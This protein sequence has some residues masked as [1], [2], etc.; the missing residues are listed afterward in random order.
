MPSKQK[1]A[2]IA[3]VGP[4]LGASLCR[5][6][7][8]EGYQVYAL[9]RSLKGA[10]LGDGTRFI[11]TDLTNEDSVRAAFQGIM[12]ETGRVDSAVYNASGMVISEF[13]GLSSGEF[14]ALWR[15]STLGAFL[16]A[17]AALPS[18]ADVGEGALLFTG[19]TASIKGGA[20]FAAF[21]SAK[22]AL[23]GLAQSLAREYG[24]KGIHVVH[25][26]VDGI[27]WSD[28]A[29]DK[30]GMTTETS[31]NPDAIAAAYLDMAHQHKS[32]WTHELDLRPYCEKF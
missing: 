7:A 14:E 24:P 10:E 5:A 21:A 16:F 27:I 13:K 17:Q 23:R 31:M 11:A 19:A 15:V 9:A 3:G 18:M 26:L 29:R 4:G 22:F 28:R 8:A 1:T 12:A 32:A 30:F 20:N 25:T 6:Y 2:V